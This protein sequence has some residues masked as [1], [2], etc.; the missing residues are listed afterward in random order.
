MIQVIPVMNAK[1][2]VGKTTT[3]VT[4]AA[5]LARRGK[6]VLLIDLDSQGSASVSLGIEKTDRSVAAALFGEMPFGMTVQR[7]H[8]PGLFLSPSSPAL[9]NADVR[10]APLAN[11]VNRL[12]EVLAPVRMAYDVIV[13]DCAPSSSLLNVNALVAADGYVVP[14]SPDFLSVESLLSLEESVRAVRKMMGQVAPILGILLT[15]ASSGRDTDAVH[16]T[17]RQR[18]GGKLIGT[19]VGRHVAL[20]EAPILGVDIFEYAPDSQAAADYNAVVDD[21]ASRIERYSAIFPNTDRAYVS[22]S[23]A[24]AIVA[25][26]DFSVPE[27]ES[28]DLS[29]AA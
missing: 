11:R 28:G 8:L 15:Q 7:T 14:V 5:G 19:A 18:Y 29:I 10:L 22:P 16:A 24:D 21:V 27:K 3:A 17:L 4:L 13:L 12:R 6:R 23:K 1:G 25:A 26:A 9:A 2:G 20:Q